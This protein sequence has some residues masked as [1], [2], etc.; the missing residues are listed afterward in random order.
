MHERLSLP[1]TDGN[2]DR[3]ATVSPGYHFI[4]GRERRIQWPRVCS[5]VGDDRTLAGAIIEC[6]A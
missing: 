2:G 5:G 3:L 1:D 4:V 6:R